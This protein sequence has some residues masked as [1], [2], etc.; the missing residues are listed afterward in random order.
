MIAPNLFPVSLNNIVIPCMEPP[1]QLLCKRTHE[2]SKLHRS[3]ERIAVEINVQEFVDDVVN[4]GLNSARI[5][6]PKNI[7]SGRIR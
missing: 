5:L 3:G 1:T 7:L 4:N 2:R 6:V